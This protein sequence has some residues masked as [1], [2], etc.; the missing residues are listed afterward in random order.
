MGLLDP[1]FLLFYCRRENP[2][3][4]DEIQSPNHPVRGLATKPTELFRILH[5]K[6][7]NYFENVFNVS[8]GKIQLNLPGYYRVSISKPQAYF[9]IEAF[10]HVGCIAHTHMYYV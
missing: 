6:Q 4:P 1:L 9:K 8:N 10:Y 5:Y 3:V 2:I 7:I